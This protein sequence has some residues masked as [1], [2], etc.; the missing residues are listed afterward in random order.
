MV[1][2]KS[3]LGSSVQQQISELAAVR[4]GRQNCHHCRPSPLSSDRRSLKPCARADCRSRPTL[5][6]AD[7]LSKNGA[8]LHHSD[9]RLAQYQGV[10]IA[11]GGR[12]CS[13][14][15]FEL[16]A[17]SCRSLNCLLTCRRANW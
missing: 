15:S 14:A 4:A 10:F 1:K 8:L 2:A 5:V 17:G 3:P 13:G 6:S 11:K 9:R 7:L 12:V 16:L